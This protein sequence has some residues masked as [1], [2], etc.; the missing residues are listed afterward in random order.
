M[1]EFIFQQTYISIDYK[2]IILNY[3]NI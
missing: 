1:I 3:N 2:Y